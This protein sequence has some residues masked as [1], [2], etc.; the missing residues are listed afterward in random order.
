MPRQIAYLI[1]LLWTWPP[2][3][4]AQ[5]PP[6]STP[7]ATESASDEALLKQ[8]ESLIAARRPEDAWQ[9]LSP[10]QREL[11]GNPLFDYLLG[12][13]A[14]D[15][16]RID[17]AA[18]A[19]QRVLASQPGFLGARME[20][21]RAL[22]EQGQLPEAR[23]QF[24]FL[25][26]QDPPASTR[27]VIERYLSVIDRRQQPRGSEW[28]WAVDLGGGYDSNANGSTAETTFLGFTLDPRNRETSSAFF[29]LGGSLNHT[30]GLSA[31]SGLVS[32]LRVAH[33]ANPDASFIDQ[34][35][36]HFGSSVVF[37]FGQ[38]TGSVAINGFK[39]W[40]DGR[41]HQHALNA[42]LGLAR[43]IAGD[44][45]LAT[46]ARVGRLQY[47]RDDLHILDVDRLLGGLALTRH[48]LGDVSGRL[49]VAVLTGRED[50]R[51]AG[52]PYGNDKL[53]ARLFGGWL[54]RPQS[55]LYAEAVWMQSRYEG[56]GF[57]GARR[58]DRQLSAILGVDVQNWP[59]VNWTVSP[60]LRFTDNDST[61][62]L[63]RYD[64]L[65]AALFVRRA[66]Q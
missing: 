54:L 50:P 27:T 53:G 23:E 61:V 43:R 57:F 32:H 39:G 19:L 35:V 5:M 51:R 2:V 55:S 7:A 26:D 10:R 24:R 28:R 31:R 20:L 8:G 62:S 17:E 21:A 13:A 15:S 30:V 44:W 63:F 1:A 49:G 46:V 34:T 16:G 42:D 59:A 9:L 36:G 60:Q 37:N 29:E 66:F 11:A 12:L 64:R 45:E 3:I 33:R 40:L 65:E 56:V 38:T 18:T 41:S 22:F 48:N 58:I 4:A 47:A 52:S 14:L 25:L 6:E